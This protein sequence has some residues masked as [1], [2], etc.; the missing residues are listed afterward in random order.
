MRNWKLDDTFLNMD[1]IDE[2]NKT[3]LNLRVPYMFRGEKTHMTITSEIVSHKEGNGYKIEMHCNFLTPI[4]YSSTIA[5]L[6]ALVVVNT[7]VNLLVSSLIGVF[8]GFI[9]FAVLKDL[10]RRASNLYLDTLA[11]KNIK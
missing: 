11:L 8:I 9:A 10:I 4:I 3:N 1:L 2:I 7:G 5:I 6:V